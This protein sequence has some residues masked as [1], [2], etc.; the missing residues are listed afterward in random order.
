MTKQEYEVYLKKVMDYATDQTPVAKTR[1]DIGCRVK[2]SQFG[3]TMQGN[4]KRKKAGTVLSFDRWMNF[5][6]DG[7]V[8][9]KWDGISKPIDMHVTQVERL[10]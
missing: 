1:E 10:C 9:V 3:I 7:T 5:K 4:D 6:D 8:T 2:L